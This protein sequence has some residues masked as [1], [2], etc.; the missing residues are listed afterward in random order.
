QQPEQRPAPGRQR[1]VDRAS[2]FHI[3]L[4]ADWRQLAPGEVEAVRAAVPGLPQRIA[5]NEPQLYY[6]VGP[7]D[8]WLRGDFDGCWLYVVYHDNEWLADEQLS[9]RLSAM[10][11]ELGADEGVRHEL[12]R[13]ERTTVGSPPHPAITCI[14]TSTP[15]AGGRSI[16]SI[17]VYAPTG[18]RQI[19]FSFSCYAEDFAR[20]EP[21]LRSMLATLAFARP[22][23]GE[24]KLTDRLWTPMATG[25]VVAVLLLVLYRSRRRI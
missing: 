21:D 23:R 6:A 14:R 19:T 8:R 10:W 18:G 24:A 13:V 9:A 22:A 17:D 15:V 1:F 20:R 16:T 7:V 11:R 25:A 12:A 3:D 5:Q 2:T 4:P